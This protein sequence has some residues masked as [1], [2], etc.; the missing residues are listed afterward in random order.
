MTDDAG[1]S[2]IGRLSLAVPAE[3]EDR[4]TVTL[5]GPS[6]DGFAQNMVVTRER[7]CAGM[8]LGAYS[9]GYVARLREQVAVHELVGVEHVNIAG[10]NGHVRRLAWT[11][12]DG[13]STVAIH[14]LVGIVVDGEE[15]YALV[16]TATEDDAAQLEPAFRSAIGSITLEPLDSLVAPLADLPDAG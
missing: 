4:T 8:G 2:A 15:A 11:V 5:I 9:Q 10:R 6:R 13:D 12:P 16:A 14:Q 1:R 7:L 3:W